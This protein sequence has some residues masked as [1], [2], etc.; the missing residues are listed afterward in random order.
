MPEHLVTAGQRFGRL[1]FTGRSGR[2]TGGRPGHVYVCDCGKEVVSDHWPVKAGKRQSCGCARSALVS[3][4]L[5]RHGHA[6]AG[7]QSPEYRSWV[8]MKGRCQN[9]SNGSWARYGGR[10][11]KVCERWSESFAAFLLD[12]GPRPSSEHSLDRI[13]VNGNY[14]PNNCRW[15][16][17]VEQQRNKRSTR[18]V[19]AFGRKMS[20]AE[21][22]EV[23]GVD[24]KLAHG[25]LAD[26]WSVERALIP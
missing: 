7:D 20:L 26:G 1:V 15:A 17:G 10:G 16:T 11:I 23:A 19:F 5:R 22:C 21:A 6:P 12:M 9:K 24:Y 2:K 13:D 25:R 14:E 4:A 8:H 18:L 3:R